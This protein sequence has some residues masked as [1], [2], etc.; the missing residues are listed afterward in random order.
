[1][2]IKLFCPFWLPI[3]LCLSTSRWPFKDVK[4]KAQMPAF[5]LISTYVMIFLM[6]GS[7]LGLDVFTAEHDITPRLPVYF[8]THVYGV[9]AERQRH[10]DSD[11]TWDALLPKLE[12]L[13]LSGVDTRQR[14]GEDSRP[15]FGMRNTVGFHFFFDSL[16]DWKSIHWRN[17][18]FASV[19]LVNSKLMELKTIRKC[20]NWQTSP[21]QRLLN[22][23]F[24]VQ[25]PS[26]RDQSNFIYKIMSSAT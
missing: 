26:E 8:Y 12:R 4:L 14:R 17:V 11:G 23:Y 5:P 16:K 24:K 18:I 19:V 10:R 9:E 6:L 1:M 13:H 22:Y 21:Q 25:T 15:V 20:L 2:Y 7:S 3:V